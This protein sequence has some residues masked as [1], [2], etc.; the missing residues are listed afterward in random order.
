MFFKKKKS[1]DDEAEDSME[2]LEPKEATPKEPV[3]EQSLGELTAGL[4]K[5][6]A[7]FD[8]FYEVQKASNERFTRVNEQIGELRSM[9]LE[10]DKDGKLIEAKATQAIDLVQSVQPD[11]LMVELKKM[12]NKV[13][14]MKSHAETNEVVIN[15][16]IAEL[17]EMRTKMNAFSGIEEAIKLS[18]EVK[19][20]WLE[21]KKIS[22]NITKHSSKV[23]TIYSEMWKKFSG[24]EKF[25]SVVDDLD[26]SVKQM[27][28]EVDSIKVKITSFSD[29]KE[30]Q[31]LIVKFENFEKYTNQVVSALNKKIT[32]FEKDFDEKFNEKMDKATKLTKGFETLAAK[33]PDLD[34]YFNL[35]EEEAKKASKDKVKVEKIKTPGEDEKIAGEAKEGL[36]SKIKGKLNK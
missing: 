17:K 36:F 7:K 9:I 18:E 15:N 8:T 32:N 34:K 24:F 5:L 22:A 4:E 13:E 29:K 30:I 3:G 25:T 11:K 20:E 19:K 27:A 33:T 1:E 28:S 12:D 16:T 23:E 10:R 21:N 35:L 2:D 14:M 26:K 6:K 31:D